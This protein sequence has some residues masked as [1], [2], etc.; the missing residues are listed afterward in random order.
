MAL[1]PPQDMAADDDAAADA[2]AENHSKDDLGMAPGAVAGFGKREAVGIVGQPQ[3]AP[4]ERLEVA[5]QRLADQAGRVGVLDPPVGQRLRPGNADADRPAPAELILERGDQRGDRP[6][7]CGIVSLRR[8]D[9]AAQQL[10]PVASEGDGLD[11][12]AAEVDADAQPAHARTARPAAP[13]WTAVIAR[14]ATPGQRPG[15]LLRGRS[16]P[17]SRRLAV[18]CAVMS[19]CSPPPIL[20]EARA[21]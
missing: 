5:A 20:N 1:A 14:R 21:V 7:G 13:P 6:Q 16:F 12:R 15:R 8:R 4:Q 2:G 17:A 10:A 11:L 19:G 18:S 9:T 3:L